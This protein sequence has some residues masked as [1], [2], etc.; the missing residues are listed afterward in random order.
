[1]TLTVC[2][3]SNVRLCVVDAVA[4]HPIAT[5]LE[6]GLRVTINSDDPAYFGG[7]VN[8]NYTA[9]ADA[10]LVSR[11]QLIQLA[12]N[13]CTGSFLDAPA[14]AKHLAEIDAYVAAHA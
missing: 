14:I 1:M 7:Y 2:P 3:L 9:I 6:R 4:N 10:G 11:D 8:A 13:S 5:M 12:R